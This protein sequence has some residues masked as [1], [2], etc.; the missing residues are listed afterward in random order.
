MLTGY[1]DAENVFDDYMPT[2][3]HFTSN[4]EWPRLRMAPLLVSEGLFSENPGLGVD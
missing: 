1:D 4:Y 2:R 3:F